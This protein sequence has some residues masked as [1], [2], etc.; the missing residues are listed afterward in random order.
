MSRSAHSD[1]GSSAYRRMARV[2][3]SPS[4]S[5]T[6][7]AVSGR[8][9]GGVGGRSVVMG[10]S[11]AENGIRDVRSTPR[12]LRCRRA[13]RG[14]CAMKAF[15]LLAPGETGLVDVAEPEPGPGQVV[16]SIA[17]ASFCHSDLELLH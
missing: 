16:L 6:A 10:S 2:V 3:V 15:R 11:S 4:S 13:R 17:S 8:S 7:S 1:T 9:C 12:W 14:H 5:P